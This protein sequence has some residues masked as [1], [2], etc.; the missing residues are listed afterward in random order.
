M[1]SNRLFGKE[2]TNLMD[3]KAPLDTKIKSS[4][5]EI[6]RQQRGLSQQ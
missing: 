6:T 4:L 3:D 5:P 2:I 1:H